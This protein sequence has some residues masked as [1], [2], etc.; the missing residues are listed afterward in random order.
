[1]ALKVFDGFD[2]YNSQTDLLARSGFLQ[3]QLYGIY[4]PSFGFQT[5]ANGDGKA[6]T[7]NHDSLRN[8]FGLLVGVMGA[9]LSNAF[10][11][12]R[13]TATDVSSVPA[14]FGI[15]FWDTLASGGPSP[16]CSVFFNPGNY[17]IQIY[18][19]LYSG[20]F[21]GIAS[22]LLATSA[23]NVWA[24]GTNFIEI[25][26]VIGASGSVEV[27]VNGQTLMN[28]TGIGTDPTGDAW[29][30]AVG[31]TPEPP[32]GQLASPT[33]ALDD[34]YYCDTTTGSGTYPCNT[35]LGDVHVYTRFP[36]G[37]SSVQWTPLANTNWQEVDETAMDG[38]TSYNYSST[39]GQEDLLNFGALASTINHIIGVQ[40]TG[41]Y[42]KDDAATRIVKQA[43]K[44][45]TTEVYGS[46]YSL[47]VSSYQYFTD[48]FVLDPNTSAS[49]TLTAVNN[50]AAGYNL[51]S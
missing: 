7:I 4:N 39:A 51:V 19:G 8:N 42:R 18:S 44:S 21:G 45:S 43:L 50:A 36:I 28:V 31:I 46:N 40:V 33:I 27:I 15:I 16:Q 1:M 41:A 9:R 23:N 38:D 48:L 22:T 13:I 24:E 20:T 2:H 49:W 25:W 34:F 32:V 6:L 5:G 14:G 11:G 30:D 29:W 10:V 26:P 35:P 17:C 37:N 12:M 47:G 3:W